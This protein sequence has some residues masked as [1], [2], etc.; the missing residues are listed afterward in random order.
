MHPAEVCGSH[1]LHVFDPA[2]ESLGADL[3]VDDGVVGRGVGQNDEQRRSA[4]VRQ[5]Q[6][7]SAQLAVLSRGELILL[8]HHG[9]L[10]DVVLVH[11]EATHLCVVGVEGTIPVT[12]RTK[13]FTSDPSG[14]V[15]IIALSHAQKLT[16]K[17][18]GVEE[19]HL[20]QRL[21]ARHHLVST[22]PPVFLL[23]YSL[24]VGALAEFCL[25]EIHIV[26]ISTEER[27]DLIA[28]GSLCVE[29]LVYEECRALL[30]VQFSVLRDVL[31][32]LL[33]ELWDE[34]GVSSPVQR[35]QIQSLLD[36]TACRA[37]GGQ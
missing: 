19:N 11:I 13:S 27:L 26:H 1:A 5:T 18:N 9:D 20:R 8:H 16:L 29:V 31:L 28:E 15:H 37:L 25:V 10:N 17:E 21:D 36:L 35:V 24:M 33:K 12:L 14:A 3:V 2:V 22:F 30:Y 34:R 23:K 32:Q 6:H 7:S 4:T